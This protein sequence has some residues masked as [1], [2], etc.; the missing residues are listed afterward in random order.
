MEEFFNQ[1]VDANVTPPKL[2]LNYSS[3][4]ELSFQ[5][6]SQTSYESYEIYGYKEGNAK[7]ELIQ[8]TPN[9]TLILREL[10]PDSKYYLK[11]RGKKSNSNVCS[12]FSSE[13]PFQ[14]ISSKFNFPFS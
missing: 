11:V 6:K 14:T 13:K 5:I 4:T 10:K 8:E 3:S 12:L 1:L 7:P 9:K 2:L